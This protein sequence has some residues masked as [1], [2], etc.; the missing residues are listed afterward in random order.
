MVLSSSSSCA[1]GT[2]EGLEGPGLGEL[3]GLSSERV[4]DLDLDLIWGAFSSA[5]MASQSHAGWTLI[6][7]RKCKHI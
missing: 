7:L 1:G 6:M 4:L 2:F 3:L 5:L